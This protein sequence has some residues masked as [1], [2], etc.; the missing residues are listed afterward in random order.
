MIKINYATI[1]SS[2]LPIN[3]C[4]A[5]MEAQMTLDAIAND[6]DIVPVIKFNPQ[7]TKPANLT[8]VDIMGETLTNDIEVKFKTYTQNW[9]S[10]KYAPVLSHV[11]SNEP[12]TIYFNTRIFTWKMSA[13]DWKENI[14]HELIHVLD[15]HSPNTFNHGDNSN[16][17][18]KQNCAP[19]RMAKLL[20]SLSIA[21]K[22]YRLTTG[23]MLTS[24]GIDVH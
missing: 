5:F 14:F 4:M 17:P 9:F 2:K 12:D 3:L 8:S 6:L 1:G 18:D 23:K 21:V 13:Q 15:A 19:Q 7:Y 16:G 10:Y 11:K 22:E 20:G 24:G